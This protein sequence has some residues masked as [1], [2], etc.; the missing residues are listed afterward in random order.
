MD[1]NGLGL[2]NGAALATVVEAWRSRL[3]RGGDMASR[4]GEDC[5]VSL[6]RLRFLGP[7]AEDLSLFSVA[8]YNIGC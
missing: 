4:V 2:W 7:T 6:V 3:A 5:G 1:V 8:Q